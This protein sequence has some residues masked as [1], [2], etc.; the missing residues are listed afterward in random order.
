MYE[1]IQDDIVVKYYDDAFGIG[2]IHEEAWYL[3]KVDAFGGPVL[4]LA[5][6]TGRL[7]IKIAEQKGVHVTGID[8]S[9]GMLAQFTRKL[10]QVP[11]NVQHLI[12]FEQQ[13]M[14]SF[15]MEKQFNLVLCCDAFFHNLSVESQINCLLHVRDHLTPEGRFVFN[16]PNP[17]CAFIEYAERSQADTFTE[18]GRF[19]LSDG[20]YLLIEHAQ[21]GDRYNQTITTTN[22]V[23]RFDASGNIV[24]KGDSIWTSRY[25]FRYEAI[26]LLHR[27]GFEIEEEVGNYKGEPVGLAGQL[28][29][30]VKKAGGNR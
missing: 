11:E 4:D 18:R 12:H 7:T 15:K 30:Q 24:E 1:S 3:D 21:A 14:D 29:F 20:G 10:A 26:H 23:T 27:C 5:C 2:S 22:R 25:L 8:Q 19:D 28:I 13:P 17:T 9:K 6:G 16:I